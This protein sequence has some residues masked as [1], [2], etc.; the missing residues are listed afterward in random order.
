[1]AFESGP[2]P[3]LIVDDPAGAVILRGGGLKIA[4]EGLTG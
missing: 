2:T 1:L 3:T 4:P